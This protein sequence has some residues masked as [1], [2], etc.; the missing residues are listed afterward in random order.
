MWR[1]IFWIT[2]WMT[3]IH[4]K[5]R[6]MVPL[7]LYIPWIE[8]LGSITV[9]YNV[10]PPTHYPSLTRTNVRV[11]KEPHAESVE[12][13][14]E[15]N[16]LQIDYRMGYLPLSMPNNWSRTRAPSLRIPEWRYSFVLRCRFLG[17]GN[18]D[19]QVL[20]VHSYSNGYL[21]R[22]WQIIS[23]LLTRWYYIQYCNVGLRSSAPRFVAVRFY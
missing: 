23:L 19:I 18:V 12:G 3:I 7:N 9:I 10:Q 14:F 1:G 21:W 5:R 2:E 20:I 22:S 17:Q 6:S 8:F 11:S 13:A 4:G 16:E 15:Y